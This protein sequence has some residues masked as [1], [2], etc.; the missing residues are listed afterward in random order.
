[1]INTRGKQH[2]RLQLFLNL[3]GKNISVIDKIRGSKNQFSVY[4]THLPLFAYHTFK[5]CKIMHGASQVSKH[6][7]THSCL[8]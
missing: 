7:L 2:Y 6:N 4:L 3:I 8:I 5:S 1:M